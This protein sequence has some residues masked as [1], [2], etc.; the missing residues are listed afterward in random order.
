[1]IVD[2]GSLGL[3]RQVRDRASMEHLALDGPP[4]EERP[5]GGAEPIQPRREQGMDGGRRGDL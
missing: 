2:A 4:L 5:F 3:G 1:L